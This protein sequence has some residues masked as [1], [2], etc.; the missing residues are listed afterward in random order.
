MTQ[1]NIIKIGRRIYEEIRRTDY[2]IALLYAGREAR[3]YLKKGSI[4]LKDQN[5]GRFRRI[6][7][8]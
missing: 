2:Y 7:I 8:H 1:S 6:T 3:L 4:V 5:T